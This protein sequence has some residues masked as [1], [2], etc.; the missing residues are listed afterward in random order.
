M[1]AALLSLGALLATVIPAQSVAQTIDASPLSTAE[2][3]EMRGGFLLPTGVEANFGAIARTIS[4]GSVLL[5]THFTWTEAG[6][7]TERVITS[8]ILQSAAD[9]LAGGFR[10][11]DENGATVFAHQLDD[12]GLRNILLNQADGRD[13]RVETQLTV[14]LPDFAATQMDFRSALLAARLTD[15]MIAVAPN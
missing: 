3:E 8:P 2:L 4:D 6:L 9:Q 5:E 15:D 13:V 10:L 1:R 7:Q 12:S 11:R 14:T